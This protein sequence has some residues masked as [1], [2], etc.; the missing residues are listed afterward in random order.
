MHYIAQGGVG[1]PARVLSILASLSIVVG[2]AAPAQSDTIRAQQWHLD[3]MHAGGMWKTSTGSGVTV[4]VVDSGVDD[5]VPDLHGRVLPGKDFTDFSGN[6][7]SDYGGHGTRMAALIAGAGKSGSADGAFGLAPG[8]KIL[9]LRVN[10]GSK[11]V[12]RTDP[13]DSI[14]KAIRYAA[15]SDAKIINVS[16]SLPGASGAEA[17]A[18]NYAVAKGKLVVAAVGGMGRKYNPVLYP[19]GFPGVVGVGAVDRDLR[20][21]KESERG[22]Q[23]DLVAPGKGIVS[24]CKGETG[25]CRS[26]GTGES[27]ALA[28]ASAALI[29]S[30]HPDWTANQVTRVLLNTAGGPVNGDKRNDAIGYGMVRPR[31]AL[32][33]PGDPGPPDTSPLADAN[34]R[35]PKPTLIKGPALR[36]SAEE[37][38]PALDSVLWIALGAGGVVV[39]VAAAVF[40]RRRRG[41]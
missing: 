25:F 40:I 20:V 1:R 8:A 11:S 18:V 9:P 15:D 14:E 13:V 27:T 6:A 34:S 17:E 41:T 4:A 28:S 32:K 12:L 39:A 10:D 7:H 24:A 33:T 29:W 3:V 35:A 21:T 19:A 2:A 31:I 26:E 16:L 37:T 5:S 36:Q 38:S 23:V 22:P 30:K